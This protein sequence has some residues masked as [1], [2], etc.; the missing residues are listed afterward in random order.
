VAGNGGHRFE[1]LLDPLWTNPSRSSRRSTFSPTIWKRKWPGSMIPACTWTD[2]NLVHTVAFDAD[3]GVLLLA[4]LP[5]R[6][7]SKSRRSGNWS[8][9]QLACHT[10]GR[11]SSPSDAIPSRS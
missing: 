3:E 2:R 1:S 5:L 8:I 9:G 6:S 11:W 10:H 4:R 7:A